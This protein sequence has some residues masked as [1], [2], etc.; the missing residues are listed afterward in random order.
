M[1]QAVIVGAND[2][3]RRLW[4]ALMA[5]GTVD[6]VAFVDDG[7]VRR[8][9]FL[10]V[11]VRPFAWLTGSTWDRL[12]VGDSGGHATGVP[13]HLVIPADRIV[14][15]PTGADDNHLT[16][17]AMER[18]PDPLAA[19]L[20]TA[21]PAGGLRIGIFG[22]GAGGTNVWEAL[23]QM[24][25]AHPAWFADNNPQQHGRT[26]LWLDVIPPARIPERRYDAVVIG[27]MSREPIRAQLLTLGVPAG[28]ILTP[29]VAAST[30]HIQTQ[31]TSAL[32]SRTRPR[33]RR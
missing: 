15:L 2:Q 25:E 4:E 33:I 13:A 28:H 14:R 3:G 31:L 29:E 17:S 18:F 10:G 11:E 7:R 16:A 27:S 9:E 6:V 8:P 1:T 20:A 5:C 24:D 30:D 23:I 19:P 21:A 22:T 26:L 32:S 12:I